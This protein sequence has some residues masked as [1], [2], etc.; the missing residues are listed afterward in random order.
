MFPKILY[1]TAWKENDTKRCVTDALK[2]GF[3]GIDTA[4][5]R[6][7]YHEAGV[8]D[9]LKS[10]FE[11][12]ELN[13]GDVFLQ[14][15]YTFVR[16]QDKR[17]PYDPQ[18]PVA[19][20]VKQSMAQSLKNLGVDYLDS[21]V[22]HG[23]SR[24]IGLVDDDWNA[25]VAMETLHTEGLARSLG[26]SN[27]SLEQLMELTNKATIRPSFVQNRCYARSGWDL[28]VRRFC[29]DNDIVYQGFSLLTANPEVFVSPV[30]V[31][32]TNRMSMTPA[33]LVFAF[34]SQVGMLPLTGTTDFHHMSEDLL[35][36]DFKL[37]DTD[38]KTIETIS[39]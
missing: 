12:G 34:S 17:L 16:G 27:V 6:K 14:T 3:R 21:Y 4:C 15:K 24:A 9:A 39:L 30:F 18:A 13:R 7:H 28:D 1:G 31:E 35:A 11:I 20:Q 33:Q 22:L 19:A 36:F 10:I 29:K 25:W 26:V 8:G 37:S 38:L 2:A 32:I 5:Q 23:P